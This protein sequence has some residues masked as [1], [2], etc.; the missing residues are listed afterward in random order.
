MTA[1]PDAPLRRR[2][3]SAGGRAD[4]DSSWADVVGARAWGQASAPASGT[5]G[6]H[7]APE[8]DTQLLPSRRS[9]RAAAGPDDAPGSAPA[10]VV[11][12]VAPARASD[13]RALTGSVGAAPGSAGTPWW[14]PTGSGPAAAA[15][16]ATTQVSWFGG[17]GGPGAPVDVEHPAF[18]HAS[19]EPAA[20]QPTAFE[21]PASEQPVFDQPAF[22][23]PV[24][25]HASF[26]P[27]AFGQPAFEPAVHEPAVYE[28]PA[29]EQP[30]YEP[31][32]YEPSVYEPSVADEQPGYERPAHEPLGNATA[33]HRPA[34]SDPVTSAAISAGPATAAFEPAPVAFEPRPTGY[35]PAAFAPGQVRIDPVAPAAEHRAPVEERRVIDL[36]PYDEDVAAPALPV[37]PSRGAEDDPFGG[38]GVRSLDRAA[39]VV[40]RAGGALPGSPFPS[41]SPLV[42][43]PV[44]APAVSG[45][46]PHL[47]PD[48]TPRLAAAPGA[49]DP[50]SGDTGRTQPLS[51]RARRTGQ[52]NEQPAVAQPASSDAFPVPATG[53]PP[54]GVTPGGGDGASGRRG[55]GRPRTDQPLPEAPAPKAGRNLPAAIGVGV[56][57]AAA[58]VASL[59]VRKEAFVGLVSAAVVIAV[60]EIAT[61]MQSKEIGVPVPPL[62]VGAVGMLV[63]AY[64][65]GPPG[66]LVAF[67]LTA[68]G[69][70]LYRVVEG[71]DGAVR[72]VAAG[73]FTAA[74]VP[75]LAGFAM[76]ML[77]EDDGPWRVVTFILVVVCNDVGG[78]TA[79]VLFGR[80]P[81]APTVSPKKSWEGFAGSVVLC[82]AAGVGTVVLGLDGRWWVGLAVGAA[83]AVSA[84]VGDLSESLIKRDLGVKD[85]GT[86]L[87]GHGGLMD[88]LDSLLPTAPLVY[89]L[90]L[91]L[92]PPAV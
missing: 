28:Q 3:G 63:S 85:M 87:P 73:V 89:L 68:F 78:Y 88:R 48:L 26:E 31:S 2:R 92:V 53:L 27:A 4:D 41:V 17:Q 5:H 10:A 55:R 56:F 72:D 21:Q 6:G 22:E 14:S 32:V 49:T 37:R 46:F 83:A 30:V 36:T 43:V 11:P 34:P 69:V 90:L 60:W 9:R 82:M 33:G 66:L 74:Y 19:F 67:A 80:H 61:A 51:R 64:V 77:A 23:Q 52:T 81:M 7:V 58:V 59:F 84:T 76:L 39:Q 13:V 57:L 70:L 91:Y 79:G 29:Y 24:F 47:G 40:G 38:V 44:P 18:E 50:S 86:L 12:D 65:A 8:N 15:P 75:F 20:F 42:P 35:A 62:A 54:T 25:E 45:A 1:D 16:G 71:F